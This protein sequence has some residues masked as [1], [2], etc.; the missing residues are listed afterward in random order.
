MKLASSSSYDPYSNYSDVSHLGSKCERCRV[1]L[2]NTSSATAVH[3]ALFHTSCNVYASGRIGG[4][5]DY[6]LL[7]KP[8]VHALQTDYKTTIVR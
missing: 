3:E 8:N 5:I 2:L 1:H 7:K 4:V 6:R